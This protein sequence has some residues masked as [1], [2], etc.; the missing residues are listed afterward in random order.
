M[1]NIY[2]SWD[3]S[4]CDQVGRKS[5]PFLFFSRLW[6]PSLVVSQQALNT[7][8][9]R[10][11]DKRTE[12]SIN[13]VDQTKCSSNGQTS[14]NGL[15]SND[16][17]MSVQKLASSME[18]AIPVKE[19]LCPHRR[20]DPGKAALMK[21]IDRVRPIYDAILFLI[22]TQNPIGYLRIA[23]TVIWCIIRSN[24]RAG[25]HLSYMC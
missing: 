15:E 16:S 12:G 14:L 18:G 13:H 23:R 6:Q 1:Q 9:S 4:S 22:D 10:P 21:R 3:V 2:R 19:I 25:R 5:S 17:K 8:L 7:F 20:L 24:A 11:F